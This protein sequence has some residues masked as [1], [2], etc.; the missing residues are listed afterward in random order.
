MLTDLSGKLK[1]IVMYTDASGERKESLKYF[2]KKEL[3]FKE[4]EKLKAKGMTAIF[5]DGNNKDGDL[6]FYQ[7][8]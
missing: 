8:I 1:Y 2:R 5:V 3:A 4:A 7:A 6:I